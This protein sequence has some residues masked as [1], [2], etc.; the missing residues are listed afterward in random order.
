M[1]SDLPPNLRELEAVRQQLRAGIKEAEHAL[2]DVEAR[3]IC[4]VKS[5][6]LHIE[7]LIE[8]KCQFTDMP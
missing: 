4:T 3:E 8:E 5:A 2:F 7:Q 6:L 1:H